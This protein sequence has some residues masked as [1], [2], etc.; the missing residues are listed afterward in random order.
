MNDT[1]NL[2]LQVARWNAEHSIGTPVEYWPGARGADTT[3]NLAYTITP[4][5][6]LDGET[7]VVWVHGHSGCIALDHVRA[8]EPGVARGS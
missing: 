5:Q 2:E 4:A 1:R 7:A 3:G 6:V 8:L